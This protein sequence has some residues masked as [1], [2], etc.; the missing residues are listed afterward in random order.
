MHGQTLKIVGLLC[1]LTMICITILAVA[2]VAD[3][4]IVILIGF[5]GSIA[6]SLF[7][8]TRTRNLGEGFRDSHVEAMKA[9]ERQMAILENQASYMR[10]MGL[11]PKVLPSAVLTPPVSQFNRDSDVSQL[12]GGTDNN[13]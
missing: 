1:G 10:A 13:R 7:T 8:L 5:A 6:T 2:G 11:V 3:A 9:Y 12:G 4:T